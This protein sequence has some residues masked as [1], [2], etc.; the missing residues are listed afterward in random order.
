MATTQAPAGTQGPQR[1]RFVVGISLCLVEKAA[2]PPQFSH[3][4]S[5]TSQDSRSRRI[6]SF[7][8]WRTFSPLVVR[9]APSSPHSAVS[10]KKP[11]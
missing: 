1:F 3:S 2:P 11:K 8:R 5:W 4:G 6:T 7:L 9:D 10:N